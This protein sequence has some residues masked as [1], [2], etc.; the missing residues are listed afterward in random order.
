MKEV[1]R[2]LGQRDNIDVV[3]GRN[4]E[5]G[6]RDNIDVVRGRKHPHFK[7]VLRTSRESLLDLAGIDIICT[8][9]G[10]GYI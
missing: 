10:A 9:R 2:R 3:R 5:V 4:K 1:N 6:I 8:V 7:P